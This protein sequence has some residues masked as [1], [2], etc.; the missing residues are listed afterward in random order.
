MCHGIV[1]RK[2]DLPPSQIIVLSLRVLLCWSL[3]PVSPRIALMLL[4][5]KHVNPRYIVLCLRWFCQCVPIGLNASC[6]TYLRFAHLQRTGYSFCSLCPRCHMRLLRVTTASSSNLPFVCIPKL[7]PYQPNNPMP[8]TYRLICWIC[9]NC[10]IPA[11]V[12]AYKCNMHLVIIKVPYIKRMVAN[13]TILG[14]SRLP[15]LHCH[16]QR[17]CITLIQSIA[18]MDVCV[19]TMHATI[20]NAQH[21]DCSNNLMLDCRNPLR[22]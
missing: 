12:M 2:E 19:P 6:A 7:R 4:K 15:K 13:P 17:Q 1:L 20:A 10:F 8:R 16:C 11:L 18:C 9:F 22:N 14:P 21:T 3:H 5:S